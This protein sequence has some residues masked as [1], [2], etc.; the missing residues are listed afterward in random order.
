[1]KTSLSEDGLSEVIGFILLIGLLVVFLVLYQ[2]YS[3]PVQG[4]DNEIDHM[5]DIKDTFAAYK[6][7]LDSLWVNERE[8][9]MLSTTLDLGTGGGY[10]RGGPGDIGFLAP[11]TSGG[12][13]GISQRNETLNVTGIKFNGDR[14][15]YA[16]FNPGA[17]EY[18]SNNNYWIDQNYYYQLGGVFLEQDSGSTVRVMPP[19]NIANIS[20]DPTD[21]SNLNR[22]A[23]FD[24]TIIRLFNAELISGSGPVRIDT[25]L[26]ING[27][28]EEDE[29]VFRVISVSVESDDGNTL[30]MW[31][32][33]FRDALVRYNIDESWYTIT[34]VNDVVTLNVY[35][36]PAHGV[37]T[38]IILANYSVT[39]QTV[40]TGIE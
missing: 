33:L 8:G 16:D 21:P 37:Y 4:R 13:L 2:T 32:K 10:S 18:Q 19:L 22:T 17:L 11:I 20:A 26:K 24:C 6:I 3:V 31:E 28:S 27:Y 39:L 25:N 5:N 30:L 15:T 12:S 38:N 7:S 40:A 29:E 9:T 36:N 1:M 14:I 23:G 35:G 34:N